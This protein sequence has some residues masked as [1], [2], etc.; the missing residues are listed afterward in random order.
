MADQLV[1]DDGIISTT[2]SLGS[3][4]TWSPDP[5]SQLDTINFPTSGTA[6]AIAFDYGD[7][8][9]PITLTGNYTSTT[10]EGI[11]NWLTSIWGLQNGDQNSVT[12][13][14]HLDS[15]DQSTTGD[16]TDGNILVKIIRF[17]PVYEAFRPL[18]ASYTLSLIESV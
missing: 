9:N 7:T 4:K 13:T 17:N 6:E 18:E 16:Y 5:N 1:V 12:I 15:L 11:M 3:I 8:Q 14:L 2:Y 10:I